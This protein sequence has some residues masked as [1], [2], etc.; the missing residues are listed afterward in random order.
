VLNACKVSNWLLEP[1]SSHLY[2]IIL[3]DLTPM[4]Y[5]TNWTP[6]IR[7]ED[8]KSRG[9]GFIRFEDR[10]EFQAALSQEMRIGTRLLRLDTVHR[11]SFKVRNRYSSINSTGSNSSHQLNHHLYNNNT[12]TSSNNNNSSNNSSSIRRLKL[13]YTYGISLRFEG[14]ETW[15]SWKVTCLLGVLFF[16]RQVAQVL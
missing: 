6:V 4:C 7:H 13:E 9:F 14:A 16:A 1:S 3:V 12:N 11:T 10:N 8:G 5:Q 15:F 2:Y